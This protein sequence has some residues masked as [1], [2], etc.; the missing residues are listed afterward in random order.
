MAVQIPLPKDAR[1]SEDTG[2]EHVHQIA[3]DVAYRRLTMVNVIFVGMP[4][5]GS[6][7]WVL[8]DAGL[9]GSADHIVAAAAARFGA[10]ARPAAIVLTHGHFDHVGALVDLL[11]RWNCPVYAHPLEAPYLTGQE[12]YPPPDAAA[13]GGIMPKLAPFLPRNPVDVSS[14]LKMISEDGTIPVLPDWRWLHTPGHTR[15]HI[16]LWR[17]QDRLLIAGDA[18][19]TTGQESAY[20]I[21]V[22]EPEMHGPP[23]YFTPDWIA[24][25]QSAKLL[26]SLE[27]QLLVTGHGRAM[28]G[29]TMLAA[30]HHLADNFRQ[31]AV[32]RSQK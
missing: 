32:P 21:A 7:N 19:V 26:A 5:A 9:H 2:A 24:A 25:E 27:P 14:W 13:D 3:A 10:G 20:E 18:V 31:I 23:R 11:E 30:L 16:S 28:E 1:A 17:E 8:V 6:G 4:G 12:G 22:Q 15:G 29:P